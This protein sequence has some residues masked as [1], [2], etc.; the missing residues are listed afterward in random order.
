MLN[1]FLFTDYDD[2]LRSYVELSKKENIRWSY[3]IWS[4]KMNIT[5]P[6]TLIKL[7]N[8]TR[9]PN[10][11]MLRKLENYFEFDENEKQYFRLLIALNKAKV[12]IQESVRLKILSAATQILSKSL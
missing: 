4:R 12:Q 2:F 3:T 6:S 11:T 10:E 8:S 5:H 9:F 7:V 1:I